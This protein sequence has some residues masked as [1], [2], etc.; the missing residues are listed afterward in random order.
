[1]TGTHAFSPSSTKERSNPTKLRL[2]QVTDTLVFSLPYTKEH[3][4]P[5]KLVFSTRATFSPIRTRWSPRLPLPV[6]DSFLPLQ[7]RWSR[8]LKVFVSVGSEGE[9]EMQMTPLQ[10]HVAFF[11]RNN[12]GI[13]YP[14]ETYRGPHLP[15]SAFSLFSLI[16]VVLDGLVTGW[17]NRVSGNREWRC[18]VCCECPLHQWFPLPQNESCEFMLFL[19][20]F[21]LPCWMCWF[22]VCIIHLPMFLDSLLIERYDQLLFLNFFYLQNYFKW[23]KCLLFQQG[24]WILMNYFVV[25]L[26]IELFSILVYKQQNIFFSSSYL[27]LLFTIQFGCTQGKFPSPLLPI[28]VKNIHKGK[29]GSDSGVYDSEGRYF[30]FLSLLFFLVT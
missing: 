14:S 17:S 26:Q 27:I 20:A 23:I 12:D 22:V 3:W 10:K 24:S 15:L 13:I 1:M 25:V 16:P 8:K 19:D 9:E 2:R 30:S 5:T 21:S 11:D 29:H 7:P 4:I 28:Y 6:G 18:F